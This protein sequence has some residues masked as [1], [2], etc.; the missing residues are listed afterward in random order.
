MDPLT[1]TFQVTPA[2][3]AAALVYDALLIALAVAAFRRLRRRAPF[4]RG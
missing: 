2:L 1:I 4:A 3:V